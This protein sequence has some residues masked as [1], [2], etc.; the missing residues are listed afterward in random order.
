MILFVVI[1]LDGGGLGGCTSRHDSVAVFYCYSLHTSPATR[2]PMTKPNA[3]CLLQCTS[4]SGGKRV[5]AV[6]GWAS[7]G[8]TISL[9]GSR[10]IVLKL[11]LGFNKF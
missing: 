5:L 7:L 8:R 2:K 4:P 10:T 3:S 1:A 6:L 11:T 9:P